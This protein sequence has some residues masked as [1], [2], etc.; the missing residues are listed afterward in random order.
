[1]AANI[2]N[3][4]QQQDDYV[5]FDEQ[6]YKRRNVIER[7]NA[8]IDSFKALLIRFE[9]KTS[10]WVALHLLAFSVIFIRKIYKNS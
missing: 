2:R 9:T 5:Y 3:Q 1:M 8:W 7:A 10:T 4:Q 6:L